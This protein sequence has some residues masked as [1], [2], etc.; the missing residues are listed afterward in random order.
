MQ[1][2]AYAQTTAFGL[3]KEEVVSRVRSQALESK[4]VLSNALS[5][6]VGILSGGDLLRCAQWEKISP[7]S[8]AQIEDGLF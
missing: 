8:K 1:V 3:T 7:A 6:D 2:L 5:C 4:A